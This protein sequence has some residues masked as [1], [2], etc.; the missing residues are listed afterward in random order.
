[1]RIARIV[2]GRGESENVRAEQRQ[3]REEAE[4][5]GHEGYSEEKKLKR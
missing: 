5:T 2:R 1:M 4:G 3:D